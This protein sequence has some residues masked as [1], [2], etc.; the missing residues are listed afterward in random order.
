[1][2]QQSYVKLEKFY[3][4]HQKI[5]KFIIFL[6]RF[7]TAFVYISYPL[8]LLLVYLEK[9]FSFMLPFVA[10]PFAVLVGVSTF[11]YT[12]NAQRPYERY[13]FSPIYEKKTKGKSFPSRH[14]TS[15]FIISFMIL[16]FNVYAG[17]A[18]LAVSTVLAVVRVLAG[19]HFIKDVVAG[20]LFS[21]LVYIAFCFIQMYS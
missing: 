18:Y 16:N 19:V 21:T 17:V 20:A 2:N 5:K 6:N 8:F 9:G 3:K 4:N 14:V 12:F 7:I 13:E 10:T 1:M 15:A 11:R